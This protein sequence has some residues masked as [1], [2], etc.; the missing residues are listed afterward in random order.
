[1]FFVLTVTMIKAQRISK[2]KK[3]MIDLNTRPKMSTTT[4]LPEERRK[5]SIFPKNTAKYV[6]TSKPYAKVRT[7]S[8][9][10]IATKKPL[11]QKLLHKDAKNS[12]I[13]PVTRSPE[14]KFTYS[15]L[16]EH[17]SRVVEK[18][19]RTH[20][21]NNNRAINEASD[22]DQYLLLTNKNDSPKLRRMEHR[23]VSRD[24]E[25]EAEGTVKIAVTPQINENKINMVS[26]ESNE[27][28]TNPSTEALEFENN[29][30]K[31]LSMRVGGEY[32]SIDN[33]VKTENIYAAEEQMDNNEFI[34]I[35]ENLR[36]VDEKQTSNNI[37]VED[38]PEEIVTE[39][40]WLEEST[41]SRQKR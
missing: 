16:V 14:T 8:P 28:T 36:P 23:F 32:N 37:G 31:R 18:I 9:W 11:M 12:N 10:E 2:I 38:D 1:M 4:R 30:P 15:P 7:Y 40:V 24:F 13:A 17:T 41:N 34:F 19:N 6:V 20:F 29:R 21:N 26:T 25:P 5:L 3:P 33:P 22:D 35:N 27:V 39:T